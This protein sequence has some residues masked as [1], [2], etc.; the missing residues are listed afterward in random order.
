MP[1]MKKMCET[2]AKVVNIERAK[3]GKS[4]FTGEDVFNY[5]PTGELS[6]ILIWYE[7]SKTV[8]DSMREQ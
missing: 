1:S 2:I 8:L 4:L 5:S 3:E 7:F 6:E